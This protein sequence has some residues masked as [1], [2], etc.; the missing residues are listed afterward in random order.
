VWGELQQGYS[1]GYL[2]I[3]TRVKE[4]AVWQDTREKMKVS[5]SSF[6][7]VLFNP[8]VLRRFGYL[9]PV[10]HGGLAHARVVPHAGVRA[11]GVGRDPAHLTE[12]SPDTIRGFYPGV[13]YQL[14]NLL[15]ALSLLIQQ[16]LAAAHGYPFALVVTIVPVFLAVIVLTAVGKEATGIEFGGRLGTDRVSVLG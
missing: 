3:R 5:R 15:A 16:A 1:L 8:A 12:M 10:D 13:T 6:R 2:L 11:G 9:I 7:D 4:S 14:G